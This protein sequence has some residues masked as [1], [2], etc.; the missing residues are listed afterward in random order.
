[1]IT[2]PAGAIGRGDAFILEVARRADAV[3]L[4]N[5]SFQEF[6]G[7]HPWLFEEGRLF[8]GKPI[9]HVGWVFVPR[10]PV[11]GATS[12]RAVRTAK[13]RDADVAA[14]PRATTRETRQR[15]QAGQRAENRCRTKARAGAAS[16][17]RRAQTRHRAASSRRSEAR[18]RCARRTSTATIDASATR[19]DR[20]ARQ[21]SHGHRRRNNFFPTSVTS[22]TKGH[23]STVIHSR[24]RRHAL[25][26]VQRRRC[27][28]LFC[29]EV[30]R[31]RTG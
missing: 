20:K 23:N 18:Q 8:G 17:C 6:H 26:I 30:S 3:V 13:E 31:R 14:E 22:H 10:A 21:H 19:V 27:V 4:S 2:P 29:A 11:R 16:S 25:E 1:M 15:T 12:R 28:S 7:A 24:C 9:P 5:D